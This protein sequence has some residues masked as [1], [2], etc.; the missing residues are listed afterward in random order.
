MIPIFKSHFSLGKSILT[1]NPESEIDNRNSVSILAIAQKY[2]LEKVYLCDTSFSSFIR[3]IKEFN[4]L[5]KQ[6]LFGVELKIA[7]DA[8]DKSE[9]SLSTISKVR[10]WM[11]NYDGYKDLLRLYS[12]IYSNEEYFYYYPRG[13]WSIL[14]QFFTSNLAVTLPFYGSYLTENLLYGKNCVPEF[15]YPPAFEIS[16]QGLPFDSII[17]KAVRKTADFDNIEVIETHNINY[18][19]QED[20]SSKAYNTFRCMFERSTINKPN[21]EHF[22]SDQFSWE[23]YCERENIKF[24]A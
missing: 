23:S 17:E 10:V 7:K 24:L 11:R 21:L 6:L 15:Q 12:H 9:E 1:L 5:E 13:D 4:K 16:K 3:A 2:N 19:S 14:S 20:F 22:S 8:K 18:Y